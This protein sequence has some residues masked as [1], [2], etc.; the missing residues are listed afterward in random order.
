MIP[1]NALVDRVFHLEKQIIEM[2]AEIDRLKKGA[3]T[4]TEIQELCHNIEGH[5]KAFKEG[6]EKYQQGLFGKGSIEEERE[7]CARIA[8]KIGDECANI[9]DGP[10]S[11][12]KCLAARGIAE[13]IR[14]RAGNDATK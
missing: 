14:N 1:Q 8:D 4:S 9:M 2:R 13:S 5:E 11:F 12:G 7:A 3:F 6:C 10:T